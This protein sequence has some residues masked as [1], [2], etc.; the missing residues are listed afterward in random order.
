[1]KSKEELI[2][3]VDDAWT[4]ANDHKSSL[5]SQAL[6]I[7]GMS[8]HKTRHFLNNLVPAVGGKYLEVGVWQGST[9]CAALNNQWSVTHA[10]AIDNWTEF[11]G[12][13]DAFMH[14]IQHFV[15]L[16]KTKVRLLDKDFRQI[17]ST[18][19]MIDTLGQFDTYLFDGPHKRIDQKDGVTMYLPFMKDTF[20]LIVDDWNWTEDVEWGTRD[21][22]AEAGLTVHKEWVAKTPNNIDHDHQGWWNGYWV[23]VVSK[24]EASKAD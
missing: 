19:L 8:G 20:V 12:P 15:D 16:D 2:A 18:D 21:A 13:R 5:N 6:N 14:H 4:K 9:F 7:P 22:I 11:G 24:A 3:I 23:A 1:M 10:F 17:N